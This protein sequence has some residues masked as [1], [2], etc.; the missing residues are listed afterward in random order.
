MYHTNQCETIRRASRCD[1]WH[2]IRETIAFWS[3]GA[4]APPE[5][6]NLPMSKLF[7]TVQAIVLRWISCSSLNNHAACFTL[8]RLS[9]LRL[10][11]SLE[12]VHLKRALR[13][14]ARQAMVRISQLN[15]PKRVFRDWIS[16][17]SERF[18]KQRG[19][20]LKLTL[21]AFWSVFNDY[22]FDCK[23]MLYFTAL[24]S[25]CSSVRV[26]ETWFSQNRSLDW[27][28]VSPWWSLVELSLKYSLFL[29]F[30]VRF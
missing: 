8:L 17:D 27:K 20:V 24:F 2:G 6:S 23:Q 3:T 28:P 14:I 11:R 22:Y 5:W 26:L 21:F 25:C 12:S 19:V 30:C 10:A 29:C 4:S 18:W 13:R 7:D 16:L 1:H 9:F 15:E